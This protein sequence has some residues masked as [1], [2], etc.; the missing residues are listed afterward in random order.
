MALDVY[1]TNACNLHCKFCFNL[2]REDAPRVPLNDIQAILKSAYER[3][4][5]Y[6]SITGGEPF[7]YKQ[8]FD[9]LDYAHDLGY[10]IS[11]L[12]HGGLLDTGR[13]E[14]LKKYWRARI[15]ISLDGPDRQSHDLL[16]GEGTFDNTMARIAM[17]ID[18][19]V[20]VGIGVTVSEN[21]INRVEDILKMCIDKGIAYVRCVPVAR[22]K[23]G[24]AAHVTA[25][26][27]EQLLELLIGFAIR[28]K[29]YVDLPQAEGE[30]APASLDVLTTRRCM[31][32][33]HFFGITPDKKILPCPLIAG[34]PDV[35]TVYFENS[36]SFEILGQKM[37][38]L[39]EG[40]KNNLGGI[41]RT[42]EFRE[43]C[44]GGCL[45]EKISF[46][47]KLDDEQPVCTKLV[48]ERVKERFEPEDVDRIMRSWVWQLQNSL[49]L[50][51]SH[52]C[53]RQA[54]YWS[55]NFKVYDRWNDTAMRF[56]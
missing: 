33:K 16:R 54:P 32:G 19:G 34:H 37:D 49:E 40:M 2:D 18:S 47:R 8:I 4:N 46:E 38:A 36:N 55:M 43:V 29:K 23:K 1:L 45:A 44:Y 26:L 53:M 56:S 6:V 20:N 5:R 17:L 39:F 41:C 3:N 13:I 51:D 31:A 12:S 35:P 22:V 21:N 48:L 7:L 25:S 14:R 15:R 24:T 9:V 11:I 27:H 28:N 50:S 30:P 10:W 52:A 42:C